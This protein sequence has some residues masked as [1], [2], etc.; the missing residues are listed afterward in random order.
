M[1]NESK[2][3]CLEKIANGLFQ[4]TFTPTVGK[5]NPPSSVGDVLSAIGFSQAHGIGT[6]NERR[7]A[8]GRIIDSGLTNTSPAATALGM[9]RGGVLGRFLTSA[10][11]NKPFYR[12][13][14]TGIGAVIGKPTW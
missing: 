10:F 13:L 5:E 11:T 2:I 7:D 8:F 3:R 14:G 9:I 4:S 1:T 6:S 12:G